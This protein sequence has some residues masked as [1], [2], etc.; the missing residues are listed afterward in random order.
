MLSIW[1][2]YGNKRILLC[3]RII[4]YILQ[5]NCHISLQA[6]TV[7]DLMMTTWLVETCCLFDTF[8]VIKEYCCAD[9]LPLIYCNQTVTFRYRPQLYCHI[10]R[11]LMAA[12]DIANQ[13]SSLASKIV[14]SATKAGFRIWGS[15]RANLESGASTS[16]A[17]NN[18]KCREISLPGAT[19]WTSGLTISKHGDSR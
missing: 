17:A 12:K 1:H 14:W 8:I 4:S 10:T 3:W 16:A 13:S 2:F 15:P 5:P 9:V 6:A 19:K 18:R 7:M 11:S